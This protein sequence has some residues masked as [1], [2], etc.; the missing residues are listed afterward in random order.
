MSKSSPMRRIH[1]LV[2]LLAV[3]AV[4]AVPAV[5][6]P[7][8]AV[9]TPASLVE[10]PDPNRVFAEPLLSAD[11]V[12]LPQYL[13]GIAELERRYPD[14][15]DVT[16]IG[17]LVGAPELNASA[18]GR[19]IPVIEITDESVPDD[20]KTDFYFSMS[21]HG[22]ERA[23]LEGGV[24]FMEDIAK[25]FYTERDGG[26]TYVLANGNPD[27]EFYRQMTA[28]EVLQSARLVFVN[29]NPDGWAAGDRGNVSTGYKRGNDRVSDLNRQWPTLG[30]A[31]S[32]GSQ[33]ETMSQPEAQ[34]GRKLIEEYLG[35]PEGAADLHGE[36][37]D[38]VLLAIMFPAGQFDPWQ[39]Q[40]EYALADAIKHNVNHSVHPGAAGLL[41]ASPLPPVS[42]IKPQPAEF[43]TAYDAIGYDDAG[44]QGDYLVQQGILEMDHEYVFS[45]LVPNN[46]WIPEL[47]Q[48]HVD[49]TR[50]LLKATIVATI[51]ADAV[52]YAPDLN[53]TVGYVENPEV[54]RHTDPGIPDPPFGF[55]Q[56]PYESTSM[57]YYRDLAKYVAEGSA[58]V[59][60]TS[61][62]VAGGR[63]LEGL[64]TLVITDRHLPRYVTED[65]SLAQ[66][67]RAAFWSAVKAFAEAGG[68]VVLTDRAVQGVAD[69][70]IVD[71]GAVTHLKQYA[72]Q[73][74]E[75][76][77][78]HPLL[79]GVE[80]IVGQTYFEVPL[81]YPV[82]GGNHAPATGV[83]IDAWK[84]AG[85]SI[86]G[87]LGSRAQDG[88]LASVKVEV[89]GTGQAV[90]LGSVGL[91]EGKVTIFG[92]V[93]PDASQA[94]PHTQGLADYAVTYGGN[95]ILVNAL[96][97][98]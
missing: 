18:G 80:G 71:A 48:V 50:E 3:L 53:G 45:N 39:L 46:I 24:R 15:V 63:G 44:F 67:D 4:A 20:D 66:P 74:T 95:A 91:G 92:A 29:L 79:D 14:V 8:V 17:D 47:T 37:G 31:R 12:Q 94:H 69:L 21:I 19:D 42:G 54:L 28:T 55:E 9:P 90:G 49:T 81:G 16:P 78:S 43:H 61:D 38:D 57:E 72:G 88:A 52:P 65:G 5:A 11:Y 22:L 59:P 93:L 60:V 26:E 2:V 10:V 7:G 30:W 56:Q 32:S 40:K 58:L 96:S 87:Y 76:D 85:G 89:P 35:V 27:N 98:R 82:A 77:R 23:G 97:G 41:S 34:A 1:R 6:T 75:I 51:Q 64:D 84:A 86:A 70:G 33:Y 62:A 13:E 83:D 36:F 25:A 73:V 68:T